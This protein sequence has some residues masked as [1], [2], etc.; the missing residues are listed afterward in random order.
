MTLHWTVLGAGSILP[1]AGFGCSGY[2]LRTSERGPVTLFDCGPGSVRKLGD[3]GIGVEEV[4]RV[5][6]SH[7][8]TDHCLDLLALAFARRSPSLAGRL[9][10]LEIVG[11]RGTADLVERGAAF[12]GERGWTRFESARIVEVDPHERGATLAAGDLDLSWIATQH[13]EHAVAWRVRGP[14]GATL[15][16]SG[17]TGEN[18]DVATLARDVDLFVCECS[19]PDEAPVARHLTPSSAARLARTAGAR[20]LL[21]THFYPGL[22]PDDARR[23][24]ARTY[25]GPID[26]AHDGWSARIARGST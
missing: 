11:P 9:R 2:A 12:G 16:Y 21:L 1:R 20:R 19:F 10:A 7:F 14:C 5:V 26:T 18:E 24:A 4:E 3:V 17:D 25:A 6:L 15:V 22:E 23:V 8:H 13:T